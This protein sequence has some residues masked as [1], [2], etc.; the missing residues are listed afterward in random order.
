MEATKTNL[1][2]P[3]YELVTFSFGTYGL[4]IAHCQ[5]LIDL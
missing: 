3:K 1:T 5:L 2:V 4:P